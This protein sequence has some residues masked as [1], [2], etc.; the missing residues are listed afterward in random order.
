MGI[1]V[2]ALEVAITENVIGITPDGRLEWKLESKTLQAYFC[3]RMWCGD[4][5][6]YNKRS[7]TWRWRLGEGAFPEKDLCALF[8]VSGLRNLRGQRQLCTPPCGFE[9]IDKLFM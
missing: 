1:R 9:L 7:R 8:G 2:D 3:G 5:A 6:I 4:V